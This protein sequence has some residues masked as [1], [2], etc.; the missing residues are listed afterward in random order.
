M[1]Q[2]HGKTDALS[3]QCYDDSLKEY[4]KLLAQPEGFLKQRAKQ[5]W[6]KTADCNSKYFHAYASA[7]KKENSNM[8]L[9]E[10]QLT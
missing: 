1:N 2:Y 8:Q 9:K 5:D 7:R 3:V 6:L 4:S 10:T